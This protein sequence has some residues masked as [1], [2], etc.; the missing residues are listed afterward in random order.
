[1]AGA[2]RRWTQP[3]QQPDGRVD[4]GGEHGRR[5]IGEGEQRV[6]GG[7]D[8]RRF[9]DRRVH[10]GV[11][12]GDAG[13]G[14]RLP[15][16]LDPL[17][18]W[19]RSNRCPG[20]R[21]GG[22]HARM[23]RSIPRRTPP[24]S[25]ATTASMSAPTAGRSRH[26]TG[27]PP[28]AIAP[29]YDWSTAVGTTRS[30][31]TR[32]STIAATI[33]DSR[34]ER[35]RVDADRMKRSPPP[36]D[37]LDA[38]QH[39][40]PERIADA[41][42]DDADHR[43]RAPGAQQAGELV[44]PEAELGGGA[45]DPVDLVRAHVALVV[46]GARDGLRGDPGAAGDVADRRRPAAGA[47]PAHRMPS[48][49][50]LARC[51]GELGRPRPGRRSRRPDGRPTRRRRRRRRAT[52]TSSGRPRSRATSVAP[53]S[54]SPA[55]IGLAT[56]DRRRRHEHVERRPIGRRRRG[57]RPTPSRRRAP[58]STSA[59]AA[60]R[61]RAATSPAS[62]S[63]R[64]TASPV[65]SAT[66]ACPMPSACSASTRL[67]LT[68]SAPAAAASISRAGRDVDGD[69]AAA[70]VDQLDQAAV[71]T[72][73]DAGRDAAADRHDGRRCRSPAATAATTSSHSAS[74][75]AGPG[76]LITVVRP[77]ASMTT[78]VPRSSPP[79]GTAVTS[80]PF[81][82]EHVDGNAAEPAGERADEVGRAHRGSAP[83][84]RR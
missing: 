5:R 36:I 64:S 9:V 6:D 41:C 80:Q 82:V 53:S 62:R 24:T 8:E 42:R 70:F 38:L 29:R 7:I 12:V 84:G 65:R 81:G 44:G 58:T 1:M 57:G 32:R 78:V 34:S 28:A 60:G 26:T 56:V 39:A 55:P 67:G 83:P 51:R 47:A 16:A 11:V 46:E 43:G 27:V 75:S 45:A 69:R 13:G 72:F 19:C 76:S 40:G 49:A 14:K 20:R 25:S 52:A 66:A 37:G 21:C 33:S 54:A 30:A 73:G 15:V 68:R 17:R 18:R 79:T 71:G 2:H 35:S 63:S 61:D 22:D 4:V 10:E 50:M 31:M 77:S 59:A 23:S 48:L 3:R 74:L